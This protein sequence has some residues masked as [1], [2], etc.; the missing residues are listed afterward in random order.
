MEQSV[1][2][3]RHINFS[4]RELPKRKHR[5]PT[6]CGLEQTIIRLPKQSFK[7]EAE[8]VIT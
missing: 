5:K 3:R 8:I 6:R 2:K 1:P 7:K 4:R